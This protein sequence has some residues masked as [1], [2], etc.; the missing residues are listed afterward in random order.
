MKQVF[1]T[2]ERGDVVWISP[3]P[4]VGQEQIGRRAA[5]VLS[6]QAYNSRVGLAVLCP[7]TAH[8]KG[9]PFE[10]LIPPDLPIEGAVLADQVETLDWRAHRAELICSLPPA[11]VEEA[12]GKLRTLLE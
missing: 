1:Y 9:Y 8:V 7:I 12:L 2:P 11:V 6:P 10:V 4:Q 5:V 3:E